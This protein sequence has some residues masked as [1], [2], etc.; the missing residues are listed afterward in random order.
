M[1][2]GTEIKGF[3]PEFLETLCAYDWPGNIREL[4][5]ALESSLATALHESI[6]YPKHLPTHIRVRLARNAIQRK[7][8]IPTLP[9]TMCTLKEHRES[10][11]AREERQYLQELINMTGG[12][13]RKSCEISDLQRARLYQLIKKHGI[14]IPK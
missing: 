10:V 3:S 14:K 4:V 5:N 9:S 11:F 12:D 7:D 6:L 1:R 8:N 2:H 13:I